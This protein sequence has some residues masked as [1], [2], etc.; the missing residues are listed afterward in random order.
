MLKQSE[1]F[2]DIDKILEQ[3]PRAQMLEE[4]HMKK[5]ITDEVL[6]YERLTNQ[7]NYNEKISNTIFGTGLKPQ[8]VG[9]V[10]SENLHMDYDFVSFDNI[11]KKEPLEYVESKK[12]DYDIKIGANKIPTSFLQIKEGEI[13]KGKEW[14][15]QNDPKLPTEIAEMMARYNWGDLKYMT[16]KS[17]KNQSKKLNKKGKDLGEEYGLTIKNKPVVI[18]FD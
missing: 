9:K 7:K 15:L 1:P 18:T 12:L 10:N 4:I 11:V 14:Y 5:Q 3:I 6:S 2:G 16:K 8:L 13:E 17:A